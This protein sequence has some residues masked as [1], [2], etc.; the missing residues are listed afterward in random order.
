MPNFRPTQIAGV[1]Q[2]SKVLALLLVLGTILVVSLLWKALC[3]IF[4]TGPSPS[5]VGPNAIGP[6]RLGASGSVL[7]GSLHLAAKVNLGWSY[8]KA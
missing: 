7:S 3:T 4:D 1:E 6:C 2:A 5:M 8:A